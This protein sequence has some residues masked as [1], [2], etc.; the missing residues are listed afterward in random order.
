M[1]RIRGA[2]EHNLRW[3]DVDIAEQAL[4]VVTGVSGSGKSS[5]AFDTLCREGQ[6]RY[7]ETFAGYARPLLGRLGR[8]AVQSIDGLPPAVA[9]A[10]IGAPRGPRSTVATFTGLYDFLRLLFARAGE[11]PRLSRASFSFNSPL[12][13]CPRCGGLGVEDHLDPALLVGDPAKS[14]RD[15][16]LRVTTPNGYLMYSQVT[17]A[18]L[19]EVL[20]AHGG[21]IDT[22]WGDLP[23]EV[24]RVVLYG[25]DRL[26]VPFGKHPLESRLR[27][28]GITARPR[29]EGCYRGLVPVMEEILKRSRND[30]ILR[31]VRSAPCPE[32]GGAR[33]R[34]EALAVTVG[35]RT[36][37][38]LHA[39]T[40][41]ELGAFARAFAPHGSRAAIARPILAALAGRA[42]ALAG[43]GLGHVA[44]DRAAASLSTGEARRARLALAAGLD[45]RGVLYVF[46]EPSAGLHPRDARRLL[47][48]VDRLI[49]AGN[50][51]VAVEHDEVT[52]AAADEIVEIGP[53]PGEEGGRLLYAG[54]RAGFYAEGRESPT[55]AALARPVVPG[56]G[57]AAPALL[58]VPAVTGRN[59]RGFDLPLARGALNAVAGVSGAGKSSL[60]AALAARHEAAALPGFARALLVDESP[61]G[62][63]VRSNPATYTGLFDGVRDL[64]AAQGEAR[65]RGFGKGHFS[66]NVAGGRCE[67]CEGAGVTRIGL[68]YLG[69]VD[70]PC[71][72]CGGRRFSEEVLAVR[73]GGRD[74]GEVL[75]LAVAE[76]LPFFTALAAGDR[77]LRPLRALC[78]L[79]LGY[80][81]LGQPSTTLSGGE[82]GRVALAAELARAAAGPTLYLL[83][84]PT[85]GLGRGDVQTLIAALQGL[86]ARGHT[87]VVAEHERAL[88]AAAGW[89]VELGPGGGVDGGTLVAAAAPAAIAAGDT[90]TGALLRGGGW[91]APAAPRPG[92]GPAAPIRL[93]GVRT[94]NLKA[95]DVD[96]PLGAL[97]AVT[98]VSGSG[99]SSLAFDTLYAEAARR[100]ADAFTAYARRLLE[101]P[102]EA[103]LD[104]AEGL[105]PAVAVTQ[106]APARA[107]RSTV[108][109]LTEVYDLYRLLY[110]RAGLRHCP[111]CGT[112][113]AASD[114]P[115]CGFHGRPLSAALFSFNHE[116]GA[117]PACTGLGAI[118]VCDPARLVT[119]P[120]LPL[121]GGALAG[122]KPGDFYGDPDGQHMATLAAAF[123]ARGFDPARPWAELPPAAREVALRGAGDEV[124]EVEWRYRR[125]ARA[126]VHRMR[127]AWPGLCALVEEEYARKHA[128]WRAA[129]LLPLMREEPCPACGGA[130]LAPE[131]LAVRVDGRSIAELCALTVDENRALAAAVAADPSAHGLEAAAGRA[132]RELLDLAAAR[133]RALADAGLGYLALDRGAA[134]LSAGEAGRVRLAAALGAGLCGVTYVLDEPTAGLHARDRARLRGL[135]R[136]LRDRGN[137]V[138]VVAHDLDVIRDADH[139]LD[140][141]P[142]AGEE[143][144]RLVAAGPPAALA[145]VAGSRTGAALARPPAPPRTPRPPRP[146]LLVH[147]AAAHNLAALDLELP[148]GVLV[149]VT[150]V[151]GSG[152]TSLLLDVVAATLA[153]GAPVGCRALDGRGRF[154]EVRTA[155]ALAAGLPE[156]ATPATLCGAFDA[157]RARYA[158]LPG[159]KA[160]G[161]KA[162]DFSWNGTG[163]CPACEGRGTVTAALDFLPDVTVPCERCGGRR[164][165]GPVLEVRDDGATIADLLQLTCAAAAA[166][167]AADPKIAR[168]LAGLA[169]AG[170]GYLRLG[171][172]AATLSGGERG[173]LALAL[174]LGAAPRADAAA[175]GTLYLL[176]EPTAGLHT[177]DVAALVALLQ[178]LVDAGHTVMAVDH[179]LDLIAAADWIV[180]LGPEGGPQGGH[181]VCAGPPAAVR[182]CA[183]SHTGRALAAAA[184]G[185]GG[186]SR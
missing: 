130:R 95:V 125:G 94:H 92:P 58:V 48:L 152:K 97:T 123:A 99:K 143:G 175:G 55:R 4:T 24:R 103:E 98:G 90:V 116:E 131:L 67:A 10:Q 33:L 158:R 9:V 147:G 168:P 16:A 121:A 124:Y 135:M 129:A 47:D 35:G 112:R 19:D 185:Q 21:S 29:E 5:L 31:F 119:H 153:A 42:A 146:G 133:L 111:A 15:R 51:V 20:R 25:S 107:P 91:A 60:L 176:D 118:T 128:D 149:L 2:H 108:G 6:R 73:L 36:I 88:L 80:L 79:G 44:L 83:D 74:V 115:A 114:C 26:R 17:L 76:A 96:I 81:R 57:P 3:L 138:V 69:E 101:L 181:L 159:A 89:I 178:Q 63:S 148:A 157:I 78:D 62:R 34:P 172:S 82:A 40:V 180:D 45:L 8:P 169:R 182:A 12:G 11:G 43:I 54:P 137:T 75:D 150:G 165:D 166:R 27:W 155:H 144:G 122:T 127:A 70:V 22:P 30:S 39:G 109:T 110:A 64:F 1:I 68:Q 13:A 14:I 171:Q 161:L 179:H 102:A 167:F 52:I 32:C 120:E 56:A 173:R 53:G 174:E 145:A 23:D 186:G 154:G 65:A 126:G 86:C 134:T 139:V 183:A 61:M 46:D 49:G 177:D 162:G 50:T 85:T 142:G 104:A 117:C 87:V 151:S 37:A 7:L 141:G 41:A 66:F 140:L 113:L 105:T 72:R 163:G 71:A 38:A 164:Y 160:R 77:V 59:L 18:V 93:R 100:F 156:T 184:R 132:A 84:E 106:G 136:G 28:K 170:L